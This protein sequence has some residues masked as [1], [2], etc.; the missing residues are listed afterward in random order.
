LRS[1]NVKLQESFT[2]LQ[3]IHKELYVEHNTTLERYSK[4]SE[5]SSSSIL[6]TSNG[7]AHCYN[8]DI[9]ICATNHVEM[10]AMKKEITR[11]T[12]L[13]QAEISPN[14]Q[15]SKANISSRVGEF[16]KHTKGFGSRYMSKFGFEKD[17]GPGKN[18]QGIPQSIPY[19]KNNK[20]AALGANGGLVNMTTP[21][22]KGERNS[23]GSS[24]VK[25]VKR[26]TTC[27]EGAKIV[28]SSSKQ[29]KF[30]TSSNSQ[31]Q[32][33][34]SHISFY[35]DFML[36][37]NHRGKVVAKFVGHRTFNTKVKSHVWV[38]QVLVT[39]VLGPKYCWVPKIKE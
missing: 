12:Q 38:P 22:R 10:N 20:T 15:A 3:A 27:D 7:C 29:D 14:E 31:T 2:S 36:T 19:I 1:E 28:A 30:K 24:H 23:Q 9:Q 35:A 32:E 18:E 8:I 21:I 16:E 39:N 26:G 11:L 17:K 5:K 37:K 13:L 33:S 25:F 34:S 4:A 6:S